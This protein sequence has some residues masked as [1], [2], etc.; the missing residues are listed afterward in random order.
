[1]RL[2]FNHGITPEDLYTN[3]RKNITDKHWRWFI[4]RYGSSSSYGDALSDPFKYAICLIFNKVLDDKMRFKIP[5]NYEAYLDFEIISDEKFQEQRQNNRFQ[6]IDFIESDFTAYVLR[7]YFKAKSYMRSYPVYFG[8]ELKE[9]FLS[10]INS[11]EKF[12]TTK[13]F[14]INDI[15]PQVHERFKELD[16]KEVK[17]LLL[18]GFRRMHACM[19]YG[20]AITINTTRYGNCYAFIGSIHTTPAI[21]YK[22]YLIRRDKKLRKIDGWLK[23]PF[24]QCYYLSLNETT[25]AKWCETNKG[26][27]TTLTFNNLVA[28]KLKEEWSYRY[29]KS[30]VFKIKVKKFRGMSFWINSL[31]TKDVEYIGYA[32]NMRL[33]LDD[34]LTWKDLIK[35][36]ETGINKLI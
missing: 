25:F 8:G 19:L 33:H 17:N 30:Y 10:K 16:K 31:K 28:R 18:I 6:N 34:K 20:C 36:Y 32:E 27:R 21:H 11:G 9:K 29:K 1:M 7:Y 2:L 4:K 35:Q 12:Y 13:D 26:A 24:D 23:T 15:L 5:V 3:I 14:T 22:E